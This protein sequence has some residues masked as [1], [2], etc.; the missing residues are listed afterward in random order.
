MARTVYTTGGREVIIEAC[1]ERHEAFLAGTTL[2]DWN[3]FALKANATF[4]RG[5]GVTVPGARYVEFWTEVDCKAYVDYEADRI[6]AAG[7]VITF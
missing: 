2:K 1:E 4:H 3:R 5:G 6:T 7:E